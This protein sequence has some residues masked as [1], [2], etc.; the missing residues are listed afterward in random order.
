MSPDG[1]VATGLVPGSAVYAAEHLTV[2]GGR[3]AVR[4]GAPGVIEEIQESS[5]QFI[6]T[7]AESLPPGQKFAVSATQLLLTA[8]YRQGQWLQLTSDITFRSKRVLRAGQPCVVRDVRCG[9]ATPLVVRM[10]PVA[11]VDAFDLSV[12]LE[13][14]EDLVGL[15]ANFSNSCG[16]LPEG[17]APADVVFA[18]ADIAVQGPSGPTIAIG[19]GDIGMVFGEPTTAEARRKGEVLVRFEARQDQGNPVFLSV[20][21]K[22]L[23][24]SPLFSCG[25]E[26]R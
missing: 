25:S 11:A 1:G 21:A 18:T 6:V 24:R 20:Q 22:S 17:F 19:V 2:Q 26:P 16:A 4:F 23:S 13:D 9:S 15:P 7:F 14:V 8:P 12:S 10:A 3:I 5:G